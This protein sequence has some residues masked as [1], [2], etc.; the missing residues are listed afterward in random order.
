MSKTNYNLYIVTDEK[1][2]Y[3]KTHLEIAEEAVAGGANVIQLRDK[4]MSSADL[5]N[6]ALKIKK[7]CS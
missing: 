1:L 4:E 2:S 3:G 5:F 6:E 7:V